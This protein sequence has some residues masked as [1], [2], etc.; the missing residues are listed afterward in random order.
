MKRKAV[1]AVSYILLIGMMVP[2]FSGMG[3]RGASAQTNDD[4]LKIISFN[5]MTSSTETIEREQD[6]KTRGEMLTALIDGKQPDSMGLNEVTPEWLNYLQS[7]V[8][9]YGYQNGATYAM[10]GNKAEDGATDLTSGYNEYSPILYRSDLYEVEKTGGY[11][12][13]ETPNDKTSKYTDILGAQGTVLYKGMSRPRVMSYA[14]F[15]FIGTNEIAYIHVNSHYDHQTSDY[16]QRLCSIQVKETADELVS[17]YHAPVILTGDINATEQSEGYNYL[18][19]G[20]NGYLNAKYVTNDYS[21]LPSS[22]GFGNNYNEGAK[23]AIDHIFI[24]AGNIGVYKH[25]IIRNEYLSDH[26][27]VYAE[28]SLNQ[29]PKLDAIEVNNKAVTEL[30]GNRFSYELFL[31]ENILSLNVKHNVE[32]TVTARINDGPDQDF[33]GPGGQSTL[34]FDIT[35]ADNS[36]LLYLADA[37]GRVTTYTL[38]IYQESGEANPVISEI[39]PNASPGYKYFEVTNLGTKSM[40]TDEY[41][42]LWGNIGEDTAQGDAAVNW[43]GRLELSENRVVKPGASV[44]FWFTYNTDGVFSQE[45]TVADFN[46]HYY[47]GLTADDI[48]IFGTS[49]AFK[50]YSVSDT[51]PDKTV[52][53]TM[54]AN[55]DRGMRIAYAKDN[56][57]QSYGWTK[58]STNSSFNGP[59]ASV[60]SYKSIST[61]DL[62]PNQLFKFKYV[63]GQAIAAAS[64]LIDALYASPGV[65]DKKIGNEPKDAYARIEAGEY[66]TY[67]LVH[68]EGDH[69]DNLGGS[70]A[71][72]WAFYSNVQFGDNGAESATFS[73]AVKESNAAGTIEIYIDGDSDGSLSGAKKIGSLTTTPTAADW[74]VF[75]EF[76]VDFSE[77]ITGTHHVTLVFKPNAGK[78][79]VGNLDYFIF[80][81]YVAKADLTELIELTFLLEGEPLTSDT[82]LNAAQGKT[83][84]TMSAE[85]TYLPSNADFSIKWSSSRPDIATINETTGQINVLRYGDFSVQASVYSNYKLFNT[86]TAPTLSTNYKVSAFSYIEGEWASEFTPGKDKTPNAKKAAAAA[87]GMSGNL[88]NGFNYIGDVVDSGSMTINSVDF[89]NNGIQSFIMNMALKFSNCGGTVTIYVDSVDDAHK[90]GYL[91]AAVTPDAPD[92]YNTYLKYTGTIEKSVTGVHDIILTFSTD[93]TYVGNID[94]LI[95]EEMEAPSQGEDIVKPVITLRGNALVTLNVGSEYLDAGATAMDDQDGDITDR[96]ITGY[97][98]NGLPADGISTVTQSTYKVHYNVRDLAGNVANEVVRTVVIGTDGESDTVQPVITLLGDA[99]VYVAN[100]AV[101]T[102]AGAVAADDR[103]GD[104]THRLVTTV[105]FAD[106]LVDAVNTGLAGAYKVHYNVQDAAGNAAVEVIRTV[107][108]AA[109]VNQPGVEENPGSWTPSLPSTPVPVPQ[110]PDGIQRLSQGDLKPEGT[111]SFTVQ[112]SKDKETLLLPADVAGAVGESSTLKL[113]KEPLTLELR[114]QTLRKLLE[115][116]GKGVQETQIR[117]TT[118][119]ADSGLIKQAV[120]SVAIPGAVQWTAASEPYSIKV[121]AVDQNGDPFAQV[122]ALENEK[123]VLTIKTGYDADPELLGVYAIGTDGQL[124]YVGG[125]WTDGKITAEVPLGGQYAV[126]AYARSFEDVSDSHWAKTVIVR[127][128]AKHVFDGIDDTRFEPQRALTRAEFAA[129]L[130]RLLGTT[131]VS[132]GTSATRF[133]DVPQESWYA[134]AV[135]TAAQAGLLTGRSGNEYEPESTLTRQEMAVMLVRA[136]EMEAGRQ[137]AV[138]A[139]SKFSDA[140][141]INAWAKDAVAAASAAGL[142]QGRDGG[143]F[144]PQ[145]QLTRA[146]SVQVLYNLLKSLK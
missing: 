75:R 68:A 7:S 110:Q 4:K 28:L 82:P 49:Q 22:A 19:N 131:P 31:S 59:T 95:F 51:D 52:T 24:S 138:P 85:A 139:G 36:V 90:I 15:K 81:P 64:D 134:A 120:G 137:L 50:G 10:T 80:I 83:V 53:F 79:Y 141:Q 103:D 34:S 26:S 73:A 14:V 18:A 13:S 130:I 125:Q 122:S 33:T 91:T 118:V 44:I 98:W 88:T 2:I 78:T 43:E 84:Y 102:D 17:Q 142:L 60:S 76:N 40:S 69:K 61:K 72:S 37:A 3:I 32:Y 97:S 38:R 104:I 114:G 140:D 96:I 65:Y 71:G 8:L 129:M 109:P 99:T 116:A 117:I 144:A 67:H 29:M 146:E 70:L 123:I 100:G 45:P 112:W 6:G 105:T 11:W 93:R 47:T 55:K 39:Y 25:D 119:A 16:I 48:I 5:V 89:G 35:K 41:A 127:M 86:Y 9:T 27:A 23:D 66:D 128:A 1:K 126:L 46:A 54:G 133:A 113:V 145:E 121:E 115:D 63:E 136:Y 20:E 101:Y 77:R 42:F 107:H 92:N 124:V 111:G 21:T 62:T 108:V 132:G 57:G 94:Y 135:E 30:S 87:T 56:Q 106:K 143:Q 74:S 58:K 12:F